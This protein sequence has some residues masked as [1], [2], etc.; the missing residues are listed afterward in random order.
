MK[1]IDKEDDMFELV[2]N[3]R[4]IDKL[5]S[6]LN[7]LKQSREHIHIDINKSNHILIHHERSDLLK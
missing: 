2:V 1:L 7:E 4:G 3:D 5:I 6:K